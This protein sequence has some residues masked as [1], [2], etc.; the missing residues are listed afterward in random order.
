MSKAGITAGMTYPARSWRRFSGMMAAA[1]LVAGLCCVALILW[2]DPFGLRVRPGGPAP[3]LMDSNQRYMYPQLVRSGRFDSAV[4][5]T[6]SSRL[7]D[8]QR[9]SEAFGTR[10][11]N[12][13]MNAATPWEQ[14]QMARLIRANWN[15]PKMLIWG[16]D[17]T[18]CE[19]DADSAAKR[20]TP[21]PFP[22][23]FYVEG[24][25]GLTA[26]LAQ[27]GMATLEIAARR[28]ALAFGQ[29]GPRMRA[30]GFDEFTPPDSTYDVA[31]ARFHLYLAHGGQAPASMPPE[32]VI[33][34]D[35][36]GHAFPALRWLEQE[37][38]SRHESSGALIVL[39]PLH[40]ASLPPAG[41][42]QVARDAACKAEIVALAERVGAGVL[43]YR[44]LSPLTRADERFWD[45]LHYRVDVA[46]RMEADL[47]SA[48][49]GRTLQGED[50]VLRATPRPK[51]RP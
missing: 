11:A 22:E 9:L 28:L 40:W 17:A 1:A 21:R 4:I 32:P 14:L 20:L 23:E 2:A 30:D 36:G 41:S 19:A 45:P 33:S 37:L 43:D 47:L 18:W 51:G 3:V 50:V 13:A 5:G 8:P 24:N 39:P 31:R 6:S 26:T 16:I 27:L 44:L 42:P 15:S 49:R 38:A 25:P 46:R 7:L 12:L 35:A 34:Q 10:F 48:A 29:G